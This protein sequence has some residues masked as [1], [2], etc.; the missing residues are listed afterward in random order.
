LVCTH[1]RVYTWINIEISSR[2]TY[3]LKSDILAKK[4]LTQDIAKKDDTG[5]P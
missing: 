2:T 5:R 4:R 3:W 1:T